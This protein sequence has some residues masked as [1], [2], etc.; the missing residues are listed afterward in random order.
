MLNMEYQQEESA[1]LIRE[2]ISYY[3]KIPKLEISLSLDKRISESDL[4][5]IHF[6][7]K[8][9]IKHRPLQY[10]LG[11]AI[12]NDLEL[13][14]T[15]NVL[16]P[17][18]ET[19]ELVNLIISSTNKTKQ[20]ILDIGTGS[21]A[22]AIALALNLKAKLFAIDISPKALNIAKQNA[23]KNKAEIDFIQSNILD[24]DSWDNLPSNLDIIVSNPPYVR[25]SEKKLMKRNV[26]EYEPKK[27]LFVDDTNPLVFYDSI[28]QLSTKKLN[29]NGELWFEINEYLADDLVKLMKPFFE[30]IEIIKDFR[31]KNRF[32][33][34][35]SPIKN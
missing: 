20:R 21:G 15:E 35:K 24:K 1:N 23:D 19:E 31:D 17:R 4:L 22:I 6:G 8:D 25:N 2:L 7:V 26:L 10:I 12:F 11:T 3:I 14:V 34:L 5:K 27:A 16:I 18:P 30:N 9:L 29:K 13:E 32:C 33:R 28:A